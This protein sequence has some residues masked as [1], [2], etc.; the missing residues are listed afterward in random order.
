MP[1]RHHLAR[2]TLLTGAAGL[3]AAAT[4][5]PLTDRKSVV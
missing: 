5:I 3:A 2:R 1:E 4:I